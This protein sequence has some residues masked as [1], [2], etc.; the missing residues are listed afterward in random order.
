MKS[1]I[2][3]TRNPHSRT[4][5]YTATEERK[6]FGLFWMEHLSGASLQVGK[7]P[8]DAEE[9]LRSDLDE[10]ERIQQERARDQSYRKIV[11]R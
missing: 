8:E 5:P 11:P 4:Y 7:T 10:Y 1:R 9:R 6:W 2:K 3:I